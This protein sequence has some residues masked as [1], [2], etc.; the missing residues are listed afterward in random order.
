M[1]Y[2]K[3]NV[4]QKRMGSNTKHCLIIKIIFIKVT[5]VYLFTKFTLKLHFWILNLKGIDINLL[6]HIM[7]AKACE[8][9]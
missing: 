1:A 7:N 5:K 9:V 2:K 6:I 4:K 3:V 8:W